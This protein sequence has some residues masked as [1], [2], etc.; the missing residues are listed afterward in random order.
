M[1]AI[2]GKAGR[3][4][5]LGAAA[6]ALYAAGGDG[7]P[8]G[9]AIERGISALGGVDGVAQWHQRWLTLNSGLLMGALTCDQYR[10][11]ITRMLAELAPCPP[12]PHRLDECLGAGFTWLRSTAA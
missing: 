10:A 1:R 7:L 8:A 3:F 6:L 12:E 9:D 2:P 4:L 5:P 11:E